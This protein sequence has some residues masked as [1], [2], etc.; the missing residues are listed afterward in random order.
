LA[1]AADEH[2]LLDGLRPRRTSRRRHDRLDRNADNRAATTP[3]KAGDL[4]GAMAGSTAPERQERAQP[5]M[6]HEKANANV[7]EQARL[8][9]QFQESVAM[10]DR[11][12]IRFGYVDTD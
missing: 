8:A 3:P 5:V 10:L 12:G 4:I 6:Q 7:N 2:G 1:E 11:L 9:V